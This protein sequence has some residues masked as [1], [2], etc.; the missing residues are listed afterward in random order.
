MNTRVGCC[1]TKLNKNTWTCLNLFHIFC[2]RTVTACYY[3]NADGVIVL[4]DI[5]KV[6]SFENASRWI[7]HARDVL[8][9]ASPPILLLGNKL[10]LRH[11]RS[12]AIEEGQKL[13]KRKKTFFLETSAK[14][15]TNV[16]KAFSILSNLI[17]EKYQKTKSTN[18]S[19]ALEQGSKNLVETKVVNK[20]PYTVVQSQ[21]KSKVTLRHSAEHCLSV[22]KESCFKLPCLCWQ[23]FRF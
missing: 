7:D 8:G 6:R 21:P 14:D 19:P 4:Y 9:P 11:N 12:I 3:G 1:R 2:F 15:A 5:T 22:A 17:A 23:S 18:T 20:E 16:Q 13:A 10:D